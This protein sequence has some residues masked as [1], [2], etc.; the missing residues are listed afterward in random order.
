MN[1]Q[2]KESFLYSSVL[3]IRMHSSVWSLEKRVLVWLLW[4]F[5]SS[6]ATSVSLFLPSY[7]K[8]TTHTFQDTCFFIPSFNITPPLFFLSFNK[9]A[10]LDRPGCYRPVTVAHE[11]SSLF[12]QPR[13]LSAFPELPFLPF[14][15]F[16][17][18][19]LSWPPV[20]QWSCFLLIIP[21]VALT[22][23]AHLLTATAVI[24]STQL[25][26]GWLRYSGI[27][28]YF[29]SFPSLSVLAKYH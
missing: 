1:T 27:Y 29:P 24:K 19:G 4:L 14:P 25:V 13:F 2:Y 10:V 5:D 18:C 16:P 15:E 22:R 23:L 3:H 28:G 11:H 17:H 20:T 12:I 6:S 8:Y 9:L 21:L 7:L 26:T